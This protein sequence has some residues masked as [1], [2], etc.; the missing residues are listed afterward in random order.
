MNMQTQTE[1]INPL[2]NSPTTRRRRWKKIMLWALVLSFGIWLYYF[3]PP[4]WYEEVQL[5]DGSKITIRQSIDDIVSFS[6]GI[7]DGGGW[8][9]NKYQIDAND[10]LG[11][12]T[13]W[14]GLY[15][16]PVVMDRSPQGYWYVISTFVMCEQYM[17]FI[18]FRLG[19]NWQEKIPP[20]ALVDALAMQRHFPLTKIW[21]QSLYQY[22][23][24]HFYIEYRYINDQWVIQDEVDQVHHDKLANL[25]VGVSRRFE[26][27]YFS[28]EG[29]RGHYEGV[30]FKS[31]PHFIK[32][33]YKNN[34]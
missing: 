21:A 27:F 16:N 17:D 23:P 5:S 26:G 15:G 20:K 24:K 13:P 18:R 8:Y 11:I 9:A 34:C 1:E 10:K 4:A 12:K 29:K 25:R 33:D 7:G 31:R 32:L 30:T 6:G 19:P 22:G 14:I 2:P 28:A 3:K